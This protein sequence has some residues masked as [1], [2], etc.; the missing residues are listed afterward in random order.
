[1]AIDLAAIDALRSSLPNSA[2]LTPA[3]DGYAESIVRWSDAAQKNA[4]LVVLPNSSEDVSK[5]ILFSQAQKL[6]LAVSGGKHST[7]GSSSTEGGLLID[8]SKMREVVVDAEKS[9]VD[10]QGGA[11]WNDVDVAA[12]KYDLAT[13]GGTVNHT[14]V[15]GLTLGGGYGWLTGWYGLTIDVLLEVEFVLADGSIVVCNETQNPDLFWA[16]KGAGACFGVATRFRFKAFEQRSTVWGGLLAFPPDK[17]QDVVNFANHCVEVSNGEAQMIMAY[18]APPPAGQ[19][20]VVAAVYYNGVTSKA[21]EFFAPL[22]DMG[23][24]M[25]D[26]REMPYSAVNGMLNPMSSYGDRKTQKGAVLTTPVEL[27]FAQSIFNNF[28]TFVKET[29]DAVDS[30]ILFEF[31]SFRESIKIPMTAQAFANRGE[32]FNVLV[33]AR[34]KDVAND[35]KCREWARNLSK[36]IVS[37]MDKASESTGGVKE[38]GNYDGIGTATGQQL[39]GVNYDKVVSLK[40]RYDPQNIFNKSVSLL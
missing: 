32:Y 19:P 24:L 14:G 2:V 30:V 22:L 4:A 31:M 28:S 1:M 10:V 3:S 18:A 21:K 6:D 34:W 40:K 5:A 20:C 17:L 16:A 9:T 37:K 25:N 29:P 23:P 12:G 35:T 11:L 13:V 8:L 15:G 36:D 33:N 39:F 26:T 7:S 27:S 38:Y